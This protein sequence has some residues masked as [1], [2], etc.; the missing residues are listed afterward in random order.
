MDGFGV[1]LSGTHA[2]WARTSKCT[3]QARIMLLVSRTAP[4]GLSDHPA[5]TVLFLRKKLGAHSG[6]SVGAGAGVGVSADDGV[7]QK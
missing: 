4:V 2:N 7:G 3:P 5:R 6:V 1:M